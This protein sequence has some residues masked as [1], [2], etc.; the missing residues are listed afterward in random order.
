VAEVVEAED[1][2]AWWLEAIKAEPSHQIEDHIRL[3]GVFTNLSNEIWQTP[4]SNYHLLP[5]FA[6]LISNKHV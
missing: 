4:P 5:L 6:G 1:L 2:V 3:C